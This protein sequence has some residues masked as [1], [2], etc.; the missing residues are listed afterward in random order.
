MRRGN[1]KKETARDVLALGSWVFYLL[2]IA[3]ALI[4]PY[5]P[6]ADHLV[7]AAVVLLIIGLVVKDFDGY[8]SRALVLVVFTS[9]FYESMRFTIFASLIGIGLVISSWYV[10]SSRLSIVKGIGAGLIAVVV[11]YY[12][13]GLL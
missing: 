6:F 4:K 10:G 3:R 8:V 12:A 13:P 5:R 1:W 7:I 2:V 11:G 9:L